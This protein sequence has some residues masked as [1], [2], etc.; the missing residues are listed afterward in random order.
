M[1][2]SESQ[3]YYRVYLRCSGSD[4]NL[5]ALRKCQ[6]ASVIRQL[7]GRLCK[8]SCQGFNRQLTKASH[9]VRCSISIN[10]L[11]RA[12]RVGEVRGSASSAW[13]L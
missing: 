6:P 7:N 4:D 2:N 9:G 10:A 11:E 13:V 8:F 5:E 1:A 12:L 3:Q